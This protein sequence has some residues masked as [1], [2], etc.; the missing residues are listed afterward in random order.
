[1]PKQMYLKKL[2]DEN[3]RS[4][5]KADTKNGRPKMEE[6]DGRYRTLG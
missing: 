1:M 4:T 5:R 6:V 3:T 2:P